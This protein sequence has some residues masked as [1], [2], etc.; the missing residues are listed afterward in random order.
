M[1]VLGCTVRVSVRI[2]ADSPIIFGSRGVP[3]AGGRGGV[4][5]RGH[6]NRHRAGESG[7]L[8]SSRDGSAVAR[9]REDRYD[10]DEK[11]QKKKF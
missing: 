2:R 7:C 8:W 3:P 6:R 9:E 11:P 1:I 5:G 10:D 4:G